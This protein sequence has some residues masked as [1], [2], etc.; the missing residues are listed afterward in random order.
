M[1]AKQSDKAIIYAYKSRQ[2]QTKQHFYKLCETETN[3]LGVWSG[4]L[5]FGDKLHVFDRITP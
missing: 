5:A 4:F 2:K 1:S 3:V